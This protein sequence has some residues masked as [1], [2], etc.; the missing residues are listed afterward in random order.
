MQQPLSLSLDKADFACA[1]RIVPSVEKGI[2]VP[3]HV[4]CTDFSY[5][6]IN[7]ATNLLASGEDRCCVPIYYDQE[8]TYV[9]ARGETSSTMLILR[10]E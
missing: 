2:I 9:V 3:A 10:V 8:D 4:Q 1:P 6:N 7:D 5:G